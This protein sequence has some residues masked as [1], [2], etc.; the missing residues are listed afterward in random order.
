MDTRTQTLEELIE[1]ADLLSSI[2]APK[3]SKLEYAIGKNLLALQSRVMKKYNSDL[4][5]LRVKHCVADKDGIILKDPNG[6]YKFTREG[7]QALT[8]DGRKLRAQAA[9]FDVYTFPIEGIEGINPA[10]VER[11]QE[12]GFFTPT[13]V[14]PAPLTVEPNDF[15]EILP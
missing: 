12:L 15:D 9:K 1:L 8:E 11:L 5:D 3:G 14:T 10:V 13:P 6:G 7:M 4:E 2:Q